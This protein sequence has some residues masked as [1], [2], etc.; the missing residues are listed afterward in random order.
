M[1][2][3][4]VNVFR[5][6]VYQPSDLPT[7]SP[8]GEEVA[9]VALTAAGAVAVIQQ[10]YASIVRIEGPVLAIANVTTALTGTPTMANGGVPPEE[11]PAEPQQPEQQ[12]GH[13]APPQHE[14]GRAPVEHPK[15]REHASSRR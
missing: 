1:A 4:F 12:P 5:A 10:Q 3:Q 8:S 14:H 15:T 13:E 2:V 9:V 6:K 11:P 7:Y